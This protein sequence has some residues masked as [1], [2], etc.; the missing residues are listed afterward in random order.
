VGLAGPELEGINNGQKIGTVD[1]LSEEQMIMLQR[2][3][4]GRIGSTVSLM[5]LGQGIR[6]LPGLI[7]FRHSHSVGIGIHGG[8]W[9]RC[10]FEPW[11][12]QFA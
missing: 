11:C 4:I 8:H 10:W 3:R 7:W 12:R 1:V 5:D 6:S 2:L 9:S